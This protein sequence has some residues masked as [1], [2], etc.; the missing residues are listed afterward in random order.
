MDYNELLLEGLGTND[1]DT[2]WDPLYDSNPGGQDGPR[3]FQIVLGLSKNLQGVAT[4]QNNNQPS[5]HTHLFFEMSVHNILH[6]LHYL[7][8]FSLISLYTH[9]YLFLLTFSLIDSPWINSC[10]TDNIIDGN[11]EE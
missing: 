9:S 2:V 7:K 1:E 11:F 10:F 3:N 8:H 6:I 4:F 5:T